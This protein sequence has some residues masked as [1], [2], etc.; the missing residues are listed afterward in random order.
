MG[1]KTRLKAQRPI[2]SLFCVAGIW[3]APEELWGLSA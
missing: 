2:A 3:A 1:L